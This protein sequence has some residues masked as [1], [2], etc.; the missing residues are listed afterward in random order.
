MKNWF[1]SLMHTIQLEDQLAQLGADSDTAIARIGEEV[2][3]VIHDF[4]EPRMDKAREAANKFDSTIQRLLAGVSICAV[5]VAILVVGTL[6]RN[7]T[8][9]IYRA[10][11][12]MNTIGNDGNVSVEM[13]PADLD[14][15]DE[16][17]ELAHAVS[18]IVQQFR[19]VEHLANDLADGNYTVSMQVRGN[20]DLMNID[21]NKM[22]AQANHVLHEIGDGIK[23]VA[24][25]SGE[26]A[27]TAQSLASGAQSAAAS[28]EQITAS[29]NEI[30]GQTQKNAKDAS[31]SRDLALN[32]SKAAA[33]GQTAMKDMT[34]AMEHITKN[35][36]EIQRVIK[37]IDDIAFQT[38]LLALNA[39]VEAARAGQHGKGFAVVAEEVRNLA[40]RSAKAARETSELIAKSVHE[41]ERGDA[42]AART[43]EVLNTIVE[44]VKQTTDLIVGIATASNEQAVGV[45]QV[46]IGLHQ[47]DS[48]TQ[49]NTTSAEESANTANEM[50][51]MAANLQKLV[52]QFKL[53]G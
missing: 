35:S 3:I 38:N 33:E 37:V 47:I 36:A 19:N 10:V 28:L 22:L 2:D 26:V 21:L 53:R 29:M 43:A 44:E 31:E 34:E 27:S 12:V 24:D 41:I 8:R 20:Q 39:A 49:Q 50:N 13:S 40:A 5:L 6:R 32:A 52:S 25:S 23:Q 45:N 7:I 48:V 18:N 4:F 11:Q 46:T 30:G 51:T 14:R 17:G 16:V 42:V 15:K 9:G 1:D